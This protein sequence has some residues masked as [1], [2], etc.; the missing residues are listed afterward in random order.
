MFDFAANLVF[1]I[2]I[3][4]IIFVIFGSFLILKKKTVILFH[5]PALCWALYAV[6]TRT[7]CPL[8]YLENWL[9]V[10]ANRNEFSSSFLNHYLVPI[11]YPEEISH[12]QLMILGFSLVLINLGLY[13]FVF[14]KNF[15]K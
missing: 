15:F 14:R 7:V 13:F 9:L 11:V 10:R 3:I 8:T 1:C 2:H 4:F 5:L 6:I 12:E